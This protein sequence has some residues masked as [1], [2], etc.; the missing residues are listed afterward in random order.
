[1][2]RGSLL[3]R[4]RPTRLGWIQSPLF[5][6]IGQVGDDPLKGGDPIP[7]GAYLRDHETSPGVRL[8]PSDIRSRAIALDE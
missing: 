1:M 2:S 7:F 6:H 3:R 4:R 5:D 8:E